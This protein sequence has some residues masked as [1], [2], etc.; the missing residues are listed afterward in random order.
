M[1][2]NRGGEGD[3]AQ[4][5]YGA[6]QCGVLEKLID[7]LLAAHPAQ[8]EEF[9]AGKDKVFGFFV[10]RAMKASGGRAHPQQLNELLRRKLSGS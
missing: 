4:G 7:E 10:G 9:R 2:K 6:D 3:A 5:C 1:Q 8:V